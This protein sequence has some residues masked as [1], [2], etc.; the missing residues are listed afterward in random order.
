MNEIGNLLLSE[1]SN[2]FQ[3]IFFFLS[4]TSAI[5]LQLLHFLQKLVANEP[6]NHDY[7]TIGKINATCLKRFF[8]LSWSSSELPCE[9]LTL[10]I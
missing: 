8:S 7:Q 9:D 4:E 10:L 3:Q 6:V 2:G 1:V 5:V